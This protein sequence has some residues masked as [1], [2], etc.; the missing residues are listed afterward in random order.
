MLLA[1]LVAAIVAVGWLLVNYQKHL[2]EKQ[3]IQQ[4]KHDL[5][6]QGYCLLKLRQLLPTDISPFVTIHRNGGSALTSV[7]RVAELLNKQ[8]ERLTARVEVTLT[9]RR[10][11]YVI[12]LPTYSK[13]GQ[14]IK[15]S[16]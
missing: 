1:P 14:L 10:V 16:A 11:D 13:E 9:E 4:L 5:P 6:T 3:L 8:Q 7:V 12:H 15:G 2:W